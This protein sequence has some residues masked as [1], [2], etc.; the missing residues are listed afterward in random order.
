[1]S[2]SSPEVLTQPNATQK[3]NMTFPP[4]GNTAHSTQTNTPPTASSR[5]GRSS[6][7]V[8]SLLNNFGSYIPGM[9]DNMQ[10]TISSGAAF[11]EPQ[12][13]NAFKSTK[14]Y[15]EKLSQKDAR[16]AYGVN[17]F[18][19]LIALYLLSGVVW[20]M[21][22]VIVFA[23]VTYSTFNTINTLFSNQDENYKRFG[24]MFFGLVELYLVVRIL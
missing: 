21:W 6:T 3:E 2:K 12:L 9:S 15:Y 16:M 24:F 1:M 18:I 8:E 14:T 13:M 5:D 4:A 7:N 20:F 23:T 10:K 22:K 19:F 17:M 11:L